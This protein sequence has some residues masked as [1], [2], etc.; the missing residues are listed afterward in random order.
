MC[1]GMN[2]TLKSLVDRFGLE[3][4]LWKLS[5]ICR[6]KAVELEGKDLP[7]FPWNESNEK[8]FRL[9]ERHSKGLPENKPRAVKRRKEEQQ[10]LAAL[11]YL[12]RQNG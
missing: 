6:E 9:A 11:A 2:K 10:L 5:Q 4:V 12:N 8:L 1:E 7:G 3:L